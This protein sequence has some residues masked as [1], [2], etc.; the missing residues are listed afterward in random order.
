[1]SRQISNVEVSSD[2]FDSWRIKTNQLANAFGDTVT[3]IRNSTGEATTGNGF[4]VGIFGANTLATT[5]L[6]GG[7]VAT[8]TLL[9]I[10]SN[11]ATGN[12]TSQIYVTHNDITQVRSSSNTT[13]NTDVQIID[14]FSTNS[15]RSGKYVLSLTNPT[16]AKYQLTELVVLHDG[17]NTYTTEH[18]T[19]ISNGS[20]GIF[21]SNVDAGSDTFRLW[22]T[23][24]YSD[25]V[26]K[27]Q[28]TLL[29]V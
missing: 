14:T 10:T 12:T 22:L 8:T 26:V 19:L 15:Y 2:T 29:A 11:V 1:M 5:T 25:T 16:N 27:Y 18:A 9:T 4:V 13:T 21:T 7:N 28:R 24:T 6:R 17:G 3:L 23:P 20:L